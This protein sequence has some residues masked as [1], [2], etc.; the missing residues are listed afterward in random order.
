MTLNSRDDFV[1]LLDTYSINVTST[2]TWIATASFE[3]PGIIANGYVTMDDSLL[4]VTSY[5]G[6]HVIDISNIFAINFKGFIPLLSIHFDFDFLNYLD[7]ETMSFL[8]VT[9]SRAMVT[10]SDQG[11]FIIDLSNS[12][13]ASLSTIYATIRTPSPTSNFFKICSTI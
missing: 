1:L 9:E 10:C 12:S 7:A 4:Y 11:T 13:T 6:I 3:F 5:T 2:S 8:G